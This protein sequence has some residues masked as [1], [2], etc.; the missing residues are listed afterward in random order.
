MSLPKARDVTLSLRRGYLFMF[1]SGFVMVGIEVAADSPSA[2]AWFDLL[3]YGRFIDDRAKMIEVSAK[4]AGNVAAVLRAMADRGS[5]CG[6]VRNIIDTDAPELSASTGSPPRHRW[7]P[8]AASQPYLVAD[9]RY[10]RRPRTGAELF[11]TRVRGK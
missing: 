1:Y 3:H 5:R 4:N 8:R 10:A 11:G 7:N 9:G 2:S 6:R